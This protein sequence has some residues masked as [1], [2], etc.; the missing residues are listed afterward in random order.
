MIVSKYSRLLHINQISLKDVWCSSLFE[1]MW[2]MLQIGHVSSGPWI[3]LPICCPLESWDISKYQPEWTKS[4]SRGGRWSR[5]ISPCC[6]SRSP[7][8]A[9]NGRCANYW[10]HVGMMFLNAF[11]GQHLAQSDVIKTL[12][13]T[14]TI[15]W[16]RILSTSPGCLQYDFLDVFL[17]FL[18][19]I[20]S[21]IK[22]MTVPWLQRLER[23]DAKKRWGRWMIFDRVHIDEHL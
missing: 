16:C 22:R 18:Y 20:V 21:T 2:Y 15:N 6:L 11:D 3:V 17:L 10:H 13:F 9:E 19:C 14:Y 5:H 1:Y 12:S 8:A 4:G 23:L 7:L